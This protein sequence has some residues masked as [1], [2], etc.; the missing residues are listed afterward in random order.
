MAVFLSVIGEAEDFQ[1][2]E[3]IALLQVG[4]PG[5]GEPGGE[6][7]NHLVR[8]ATGNGEVGPA[9]KLPHDGALDMPDLSTCLISKS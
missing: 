4:S 3:F 2:G 5:P 9:P 1:I 6:H 8:I 7:S